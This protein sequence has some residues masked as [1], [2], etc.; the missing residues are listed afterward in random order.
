MGISSIPHNSVTT[1]LK[2][3]GMKNVGRLYFLVND[4]GSHLQC[5]QELLIP[6]YCIWGFAY[7]GLPAVNVGPLRL[8]FSTFEDGL[9]RQT[10]KDMEENGPVFLKYMHSNIGIET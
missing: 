5:I 7:I 3:W 1:H 8:H 6:V 2:S 4:D 10:L 9:I